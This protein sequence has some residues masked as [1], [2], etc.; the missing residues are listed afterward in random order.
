MR[1][2]KMRLSKVLGAAF[3][4]ASLLIVGGAGALTPATTP[5]ATP[6]ATTAAHTLDATDV[7]AFLDGYMPYALKAGDIPGAV[8]VVVKDGQVVTE[9]GYGYADVA[10]R[11]PVDPQKTLF[12]PGSISKLFM[13]TAVMQL[14]EQGKLDLDADINKYLDFKIPPRDGKPITMR[15]LMTHTPGFEEWGKRLFVANAGRMGTLHDYVIHVPARIY[16]PGKTI[17]YSNY[18]AALAGYIVQRV[19]GEPFAQ[20]IDH[21]ILT[22]LNM[23]HST[24]V[25]PLP[26]NLAPDM[27]KGYGAASAGPRPFEFVNGAPAGSLSATGDDMSHFMI[28]H[29]QNG[30]YDGV[31][32]LKP[33][34]AKY[35]HQT[36]FTPVPPLNGMA[37]G[38]YREDRNGHAVVAHAGDTQ[39]FHSELHLLIDDNVGIFISING[40]KGI[41]A[42]LGNGVRPVL[43]RAFMDRYFPAPVT[44]EPPTASTAK[45]DAALIAGRY[46]ASGRSATNFLSIGS[47]LGQTT[48]TAAPDGTIKVSSYKDTA[49]GVRSWREIGPMLWRNVNGT[50]RMAATVENGRVTSMRQENDPTVEM[51]I[52]VPAS[53]DGRWMMPLLYVS[54]LILLTC[55]ATWPI[56]AIGRAAYGKNFTL[57]G[58]P[59]ML[60]RLVRVSAI[61]A[62]CLVAGWMM[63]LGHDF[64]SFDTPLDK[65]LRLMQL[66]GV[67]T[68]LGAVVGLWNLAT[69]WGDASRGWWAKLS[70]LLI[71]V[72]LL[73]AVWFIFALHLITLSLDY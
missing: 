65:W 27:A 10:K 44:P 41:A 70:S 55:V 73:S 52:P 25:Q 33:E 47:L 72:A 31:Q 35:M 19:S 28:A 13:W 57:S 56:S 3:A 2:S 20:Y 71:A 60:Y 8:V 54:L 49:G 21:H 67:L 45:H 63:L 69:V 1:L 50:D 61:V 14:Q 58:R 26:A 40:G 66:I 22:P 51:L 12:R 16:A 59:A 18:G 62:L 53:I 4:A 34:T 24:F 48:V 42:E 17:A 38:F 23:H 11:T 6:P 64:G 32:I 68:I 15:N 5:V 30:Q 7:N 37:L 29:L 36:A 46:V 43:Y 39:L 9:R